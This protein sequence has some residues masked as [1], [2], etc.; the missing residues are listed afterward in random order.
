MKHIYFTKRQQDILKALY[1]GHTTRKRLAAKL[2]V[3]PATIRTHLSLMFEATGIHSTA[4]LLAAAIRNGWIETE[5]SVTANEN[6][7]SRDLS[8]SMNCRS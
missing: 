5:R 2:G 3:T 7:Y 8:D 6:S 1:E 4:G